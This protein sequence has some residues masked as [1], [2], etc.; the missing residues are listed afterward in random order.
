MELITNTF[1]TADYGKYIYEE[2]LSDTESGNY[3]TLGGKTYS[4]ELSDLMSTNINE[5][6][7]VLVDAE[8]LQLKGYKIGL[9]IGLDN[10]WYLNVTVPNKDQYWNTNVYIDFSDTKYA[11]RKSVV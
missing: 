11:D 1:W 10:I 7:W 2:A 5:Y 3:K 8:S 6:K 4:I 9:S